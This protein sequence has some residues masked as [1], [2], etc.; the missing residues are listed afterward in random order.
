VKQQKEI[1][2]TRLDNA[3]KFFT[4][5][6]NV[7]DSKV[8]RLHCELY[9]AVDAE[10]LQKALDRTLQDFPLYQSVLR[11]GAFWFYLESSE[12]KPVVR[13][14]MLP[15]CAPIYQGQKNNLLFR[16]SYFNKRINFEVFHALSDGTGGF[17][18][19][20][21]MVNHYLVLRYKET[22]PSI[23]FAKHI[24]SISKQKDDSFGRHFIGGGLFRRKKEAVK[25]GKKTVAYQIH[26]NRFS[27]NRIQLIEGAMLTTAVLEQAHK[28]HTTM[29][30]FIA[31]LLICSIY[32]EMP[33][34]RK[35][36]PV[37]LSIPV[38]L[39]QYFESG[40]AR[41]FFSTMNVGYDFENG[42]HDL[43]AVIAGVSGSFGRDLTQ[44]QLNDK[45]NKLMS[46]EQNPFIRILPLPLKNLIIRIAA[47]ISD[48]QVTSAL[49][50]V[51]Q[52]SLPPELSAMISRFGACS[53][54]RT[55]RIIM[56]SYGDRTVMSFTSPFQET[57]IQRTFFYTLSQ[58]GIEIEISSNL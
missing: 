22:V 24:S 43:D 30:I 41:N 38:N 18:F 57:D 11:K 23:E 1:E 2:W 19:L 52:I 6:Y 13:E 12:L 31:S 48:R 16:V 28:H 35:K 58:M 20:Q 10:L 54:A 49:S 50:N 55:P 3:S 27:E 14:E 15:V 47:K 34:S 9:E 40:T 4:A 17:W 45:M 51:G 29:T 26:G 39:R 44:E 8:F 36:L 5:T 53:S 7:K 25:S 37:V 46:L 56:C 32:K 21:A 33:A 42:A